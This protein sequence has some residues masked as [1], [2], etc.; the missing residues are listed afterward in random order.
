MKEN[1]LIPMGSATKIYTAVAVMQLH[2]KGLLDIDRPVHE[3]VDPFLQRTNS[4][5]LLELWGGDETINRVTTRELM[6]MRGCLSDYDDE[7]LQNFVLDPSNAGVTVNPYDYLHTWAQKSFL[8]EPG[9]GGSYSSIGFV[10]LGLVCASSTNATQWSDF[11]QKSI[12][13]DSLRQELDELVFSLGGSCSETIQNVGHQYAATF[14]S[15]GYWNTIHWEDIYN[16]DCL[17]GWTMGN[18]AAAASNTA[19]ALYHLFSPNTK[20]PLVTQDSLKQMMDFKPLTVGWSVGLEYGLGMMRANYFPRDGVPSNLTTFVGHAGQDYG[21]SAFLHEYNEALDVAITLSSNTE[22]GM[23]CS[24][25]AIM[26]NF[27][28][29]AYLGCIVWDSIV[30][31][32]TNGTVQ[33]LTC[34]GERNRRHRHLVQSHPPHQTWARRGAAYVRR[35]LRLLRLPEA[36]YPWRRAEEAFAAPVFRGEARRRYFKKG[37]PDADAVRGLLG[38]RQQPRAQLPSF[39]SVVGGASA[40]PGEPSR[41]ASDS[42]R[43]DDGCSRGC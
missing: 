16:F 2:E 9:T 27:Q 25:E 38:R 17:N 21:S 31:I 12:F 35:L 26:D 18:I 7:K 20:T 13:P 1:T 40:A 41:R 39:S 36:L 34:A 22:Y 10:I 32:A 19:A 33:H 4:T 37:A 11:D 42:E 8:C 30:Q 5:T 28:D 24:L 14:T 29:S 6:G 23:N 43:N 3:I 15:N